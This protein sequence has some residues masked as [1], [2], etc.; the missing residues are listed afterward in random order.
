MQG[1]LPSGLLTFSW[2]LAEKVTCTI[3]FG[4]EHVNACGQ[5]QG[6]SVLVSQELDTQS[7]KSPVGQL[8]QCPTPPQDS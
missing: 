6:V 8:A 7:W 1:P 2:P 4:N 5:R 3:I